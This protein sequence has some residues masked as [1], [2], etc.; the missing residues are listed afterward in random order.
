MPCL[1]LAVVAALGNAGALNTDTRPLFE[2]SRAD[3][4]CLSCGFEH[5]E[6]K[7]YPEKIARYKVDS[8]ELEVGEKHCFTKK[9]A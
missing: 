3:E 9:L 1:C 2:I 4:L 8:S 6:L 7:E 5:A